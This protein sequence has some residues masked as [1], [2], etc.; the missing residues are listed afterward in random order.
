VKLAPGYTPPAGTTFPI[1]SAAN[2][3]GGFVQV[4]GANVTYGPNG[5]TVQPTGN[6]NALQLVSAASRKMHGAAGAMDIPLP[7]TGE[8]GV[9]CRSSGGNHT[10]VFTFSND[11]VSGNVS[12]T[13][14]TG[15]VA[16]RTVAGKT[17]NIDLTGV[18][19]AQQI[20]VTLSDVTDVF[21]QVI[22]S[23]TVAMKTLVGDT[24]GNRQVNAT[25]IAQVKAQSG[26]PVTTAN[27][28]QDVTPNGAITASD[29]GLVK[30][31]SGA[32]VP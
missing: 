14:G 13:G 27:F 11:I 10:L 15:A 16:A 4:T 25:D 2:V 23:A 30:S 18:A 19:D 17:L 1:L 21:S 31:R 32:T 22:P 24:N 29:I 5:V 20:T 9:E 28:R 12:V 8:P 26:L 3:T 7:L 6:G